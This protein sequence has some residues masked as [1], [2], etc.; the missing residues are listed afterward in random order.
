MWAQ[1]KGVAPTGTH[2]LKH[3]TRG[4]KS[5]TGTGAIACSTYTEVCTSKHIPHP[6][7]HKHRRTRPHTLLPLTPAHHTQAR[8]T[9]AHTCSRTCAHLRA[10]AYTRAHTLLRVH[11]PSFTYTHRAH[12]LTPGVHTLLCTH[13]PWRSH[14]HPAEQRGAGRAA[15]GARP[16]VARRGRGA[17]DRGG[18]WNPLP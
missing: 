1:G 3:A 6:S 16:L 18:R 5:Q 14:A 17:V 13:L 8:N 4:Y 7:H 11:I 2:T 9:R 10:H 12:T 15:T